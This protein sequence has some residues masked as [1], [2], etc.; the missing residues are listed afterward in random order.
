[1]NKQPAVYL[2][3]NRPDGTLYTGVTSDLPKRIWQHRNKVAKVFTTKE[4]LINSS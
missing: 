3:T 1:M 2:F 4:P